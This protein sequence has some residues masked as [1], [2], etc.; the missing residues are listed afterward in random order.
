MATGIEVELVKTRICMISDTHNC[1]PLPPG[2]VHTPYRRP[3]PSADVLLHGGDLTFVGREKEHQGVIDMLKEADAELKIVIAGNHDITLDEEYY[4]SVGHLKHKWTG[5]EDL[6]KI[7]ELYCGEEAQRY[8]IVYMEEGVRT[9]RLKNGAQFT[10][11]ATPYQPEFCRWAFA[12]NRAHDRFNPSPEGALF[13]AQNPVPSFPDVHI[14]LTHGPPLGFLDLVHSNRHVGCQHLRGAVGRARPLIHCFGHIH[15][16]HGAV[17]MNWDA[18]SLKTIPQ[19]RAEELKNRCA[20][21]DLS[22]DGGDPLR[23]GAETLFVNASI[24]TQGYDPLNAPWL[25]DV[26]LPRVLDEEMI[27]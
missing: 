25:V 2:E 27:G 22:R 8:G 23:F 10:I 1:S 12:Y 19:N 5:P 21:V 9:F 14:L 13:Q 4:N 15:E 11:Y 20:F 3:L 16:G 26:D 6:A 17:R 7:R 18:D 24:M